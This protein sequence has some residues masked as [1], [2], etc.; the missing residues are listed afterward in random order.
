MFD[1]VNIMPSQSSKSPLAP[2]TKTH[3]FVR[4]NTDESPL[5]KTT[6]TSVPNEVRTSQHTNSLSPRSNESNHPEEDDDISDVD[7]T[8]RR[9]SC[10]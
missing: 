4:K 10:G 8:P 7:K 1:F 3:S 6:S 5:I 2:F 9:E